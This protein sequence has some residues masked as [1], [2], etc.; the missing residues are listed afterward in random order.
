[1]SEKIP[2]IAITQTSV[3]RI[4]KSEKIR[5]LIVADIHWNDEY[6]SSSREQT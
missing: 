3:V 6:G 4:Q 2:R 1:M 5:E